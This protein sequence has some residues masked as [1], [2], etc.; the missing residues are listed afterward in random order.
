M[1]GLFKEA[2]S[3]ELL[4][5]LLADQLRFCLDILHLVLEDINVNFGGSHVIF[6]LSLD[7]LVL[8]L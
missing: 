2:N 5:I 8:L 6:K 4:I 7:S 3:L 1:V